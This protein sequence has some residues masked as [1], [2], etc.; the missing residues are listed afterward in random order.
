[1]AFWFGKSVWRARQSVLS[2]VFLD[3]IAR[4]ELPVL[5]D[6]RFPSLPA[7]EA[8]GLR[9]GEH[10]LFHH[11]FQHIDAAMLDN[12]V[13]EGLFLRFLLIVER[14]VL[15]LDELQVERHDF[16]LPGN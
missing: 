14:I 10:A 11:Q 7:L 8:L 9:V 1:M 2:G 6:D 4:E 3:E 15:V 5:L 13:G 16:R 12:E